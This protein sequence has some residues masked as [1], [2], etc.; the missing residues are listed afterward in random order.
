MRQDFL[1]TQINKLIVLKNCKIQRMLDGAISPTLL[2]KSLEK[3]LLS[4]VII[5]PI[6]GASAYYTLRKMR[7]AAYPITVKGD[8]FEK[9]YAFLPALS[10]I[11][12]AAVAGV[13]IRLM[14]EE[15]F[16]IA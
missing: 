16:W 7:I 11:L 8:D 10:G 5:C 14:D 6:A 12:T 15:D 4:G 2:L 13:K 3:E 1:K 9:E